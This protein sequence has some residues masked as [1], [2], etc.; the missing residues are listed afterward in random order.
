M[1]RLLSLLT[2][3]EL[4][5]AKEEL[6]GYNKT[7]VL[8]EGITRKTRDYLIQNNPAANPSWDI[9]FIVTKL[10]ILEEI[11]QRWYDEGL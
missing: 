3:E 4:R 5:T 9:G 1:S 8:E 11:A 6:D 2:N 10:T 7:G